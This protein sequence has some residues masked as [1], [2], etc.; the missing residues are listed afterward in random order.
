[1]LSSCWF[2]MW[3]HNGCQLTRCSVCCLYGLYIYSDVI[4]GRAFDYQKTV[5][6]FVLRNGDLHP[7]KLSKIE[8]IKMVT[9]WLKAFHS[10]TTQISSTK[11]P[12]LSH[13][14]AIFHG[15]QDKLTDILHALPNP[16]SPNIKKRLTDAHQKL[17]NYYYKFDESP[18]YTWAAHIYI[19]P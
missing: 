18:F 13:V 2:S 3:G 12:T 17:S 1:M 10:A 19:P 8:S 14:H 11:I 9:S 15:L 16:F 6:W 7:F 4:L 5:N